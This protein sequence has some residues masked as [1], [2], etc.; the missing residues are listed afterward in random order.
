MALNTT[1]GGHLAGPGSA[2]FA[3]ASGMK[4]PNWN[5]EAG[6]KGSA[7]ALPKYALVAR[8][9]SDVQA[10]IR[11]ANEHGVQVSVKSTG[12][13]YTGRSTAAGT[14]LV[15]VHFMRDIQWHQA[16]TDGCSD[17][18]S[19][20]AVTTQ[21]G[22]DWGTLYP[23]VDRRG[24]VV[25]GGGGDTVGT[26][27]GYVLGGGHGALS[28]SLGLA[29]DNVLSIDIVVANGSLVTASACRSPELFWALRGGGGGTYG[30]VVSV[31]HR[32]HAN[33]RNGFVGLKASYPMS[34]GN[35]SAWLN[36]FMR[37]Q[38][39]LPSSWGCY[40]SCIP[41]VAV[42]AK[43][44]SWTLNCLHYGV[45]NVTAA[46]ASLA[47]IKSAFDAHPAS[48]AMWSVSAYA[49]FWAWKRGDQGGDTSGVAAVLTSRI[50]P[51]SSFATEAVPPLA[52]SLLGAV[53][54][55]LNIQVV[56]LLGGAAG[57]KHDNS[58]SEWMRGGLWHVVAASGWLPIEP[59]VVQRYIIG[60]VRNYGD[61]LRRLVPHS[62]AYLNEN[63]WA[64]PRWEDSF[65]GGNYAR[66]LAIKR[67]VDPADMFR[68]RH[69][70]GSEGTG[71]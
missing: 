62:G 70:V 38:P 42:F 6:H 55:G 50:L 23:E 57:G 28:R 47:P 9:V 60:R 35:V 66:L 13:S 48:H 24:F 31:T 4:Y 1:V 33:P 2:F 18:G 39:E 11:F 22:I 67:R 49:S 15:Y 45:T 10:A 36:A 8:G 46:E 5:Y 21:P 20:P 32:L 64:E 27:G 34:G 19:M 25:V 54:S 14:M 29:S 59:D 7:S 56:L 17:S 65:F 52:A 40:I 51:P 43:H 3:N 30:V 61:E 44:A 12:H 71:F 53:L 69:C 41:G 68:C 63:D 16:F 58:V 26:A 37:A